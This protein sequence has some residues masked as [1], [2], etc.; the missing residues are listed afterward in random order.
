MTIISISFPWHFLLE[1]L[2]LL[3]A[4][5]YGA[6]E[7]TG[8]F[9]LNVEVLVDIFGD[10]FVVGVEHV[11]R[12]YD[13]LGEAGTVRIV[14]IYFAGTQGLGQTRTAVEIYVGVRTRL[15]YFLIILIG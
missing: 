4:N 7:S 1:T 6:L 9:A 12:F 11:L 14:K 2:R 10:F 3:F 13:V 8:Q 15:C 5:D